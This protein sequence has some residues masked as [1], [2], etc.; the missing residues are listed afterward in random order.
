MIL[1][2]T[3]NPTVLLTLVIYIIK[4]LNNKNPEELGTV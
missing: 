1:S 4:T 3:R 2:F